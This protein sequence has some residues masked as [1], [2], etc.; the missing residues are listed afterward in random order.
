MTGGLLHSEVLA[1]MHEALAQDVLKK[2][3]VLSLMTMLKTKSGSSFV[4][5]IDI[6]AGIPRDVIVNDAVID[7]GINMIVEGLK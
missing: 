5:F 2:Y 1:R 4:K 6:A 3:S 7:T